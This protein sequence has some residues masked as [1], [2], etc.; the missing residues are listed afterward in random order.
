MAAMFFQQGADDDD[1]DGT[2]SVAL[3]SGNRC[4][5][6]LFLSFFLYCEMKKKR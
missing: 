1:D 4:T 3:G 2:N 5:I 6:F